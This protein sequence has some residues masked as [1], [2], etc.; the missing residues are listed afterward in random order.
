[1]TETRFLK[2][3][4]LVCRADA[5][6]LK[7]HFKLFF[8]F[9]LNNYNGTH[10]LDSFSMNSG[11]VVPKIKITNFLKTLAV[12]TVNV[13]T[14]FFYVYTYGLVDTWLNVFRN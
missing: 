7:G 1:M 10:V 13:S 12:I 5:N 3:T 8:R 14:Y 9:T 4:S 2:K 11:K 6:N